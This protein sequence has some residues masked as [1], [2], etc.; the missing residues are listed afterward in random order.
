MKR[1]NF[2]I[3]IENKNG[4]EILRWLTNNGY[5]NR[6]AFA[7][8]IAD[9]YSYFV[10]DDSVIDFGLTKLLSIPI[11]SLS[12]LMQEQYKN[13][14]GYRIIKPDYIGL[15]TAL[16]SSY[17][18]DKEVIIDDVFI[19]VLKTAGVL[20]I[21]FEPVYEKESLVE[22]I[23]PNIDKR[24]YVMPSGNVVGEK[25]KDYVVGDWV[26]PLPNGCVAFNHSRQIGE[27]YLVSDVNWGSVILLTGD[28]KTYDGQ[29][30]ILFDEVRPALKWE[31]DAAIKRGEEL[32]KELKT[33]ISEIETKE[34]KTF[35]S[36]IKN[37]INNLEIKINK[38]PNE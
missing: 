28:N 11:Y 34:L 4:K 29:G 3:R 27:A 7:G 13:I 9:D 12:E 35:L 25:K 5:Q 17:H 15:I 38:I 23:F 8:I 18:Y 16:T 2:G 31:I 20:D 30:I 6:R 10:L 32:N 21:W 33:F 1:K 22:S 19:S 37:A 14:V 26:V 24:P 36:E